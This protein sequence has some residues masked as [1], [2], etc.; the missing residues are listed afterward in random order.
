MLSYLEQEC[1][2]SFAKSC[3]FY[4]PCSLLFCCLGVKFWGHKQQAE[5]VKPSPLFSCMGAFVTVLNLYILLPAVFS[6]P[7]PLFEIKSFLLN[8]VVCI[9]SCIVSHDLFKIGCIKQES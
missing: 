9:F 2:R 3:F 7:L 5:P 4:L 8:S 1:F 6:V